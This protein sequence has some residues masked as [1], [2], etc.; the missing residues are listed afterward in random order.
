MDPSS[1]PVLPVRRRSHSAPTT[2]IGV[3]S[4]GT[5]PFGSGN[6]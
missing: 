5:S 3:L 2:R 6:N 1:S 4:L